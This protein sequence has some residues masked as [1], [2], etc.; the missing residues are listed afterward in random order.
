MISY[1]APDFSS[2][3]KEI[4]CQQR[5]GGQKNWESG[6]EFQR[7]RFMAGSPH[8][9]L[10]AIASHQERKKEKLRFPGP[11]DAQFSHNAC[12]DT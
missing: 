3:G 8:P 5:M 2:K 11:C 7:F 9:K 12:Q 6:P 4:E 10:N 1:S